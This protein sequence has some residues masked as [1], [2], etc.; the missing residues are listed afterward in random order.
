MLTE[1]LA[2]D[3]HLVGLDS[4]ELG[5]GEMLRERVNVLFDEPGLFTNGPSF[6]G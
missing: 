4:N 3:L 5:T 2:A 1:A 6:S